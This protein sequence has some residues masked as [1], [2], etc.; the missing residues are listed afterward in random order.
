MIKAALY[1]ILLLGLAAWAFVSRDCR[2]EEE[3]ELS[4][5]LR[6]FQRMAVHIWQR[7][8]PVRQKIPGL[9][10]VRADLRLLHPSR[11]VIGRED[12]YYTGK[13]RNL[14]LFVCAADLLAAA[15]FLG[16]QTGRILEN[17]RRIERNSYGGSDRI[18]SLTAMD[19][20]RTDLGRFDLQVSARRYR[21][22]D[23]IRM[24][25]DL[26]EKL[27]DLILADNPDLLHVSTDLSL[28]S[29]AE[30]YPFILQWDTAS[31]SL[32]NT[33]G[34]VHPDNLENGTPAKVRLRASLKYDPW[35]FETEIPVTV[36]PRSLTEEEAVR[37]SI[38]ESLAAAET[39]GRET[40]ACLLPDRA[41]GISL[42]WREN[43]TDLSPAVLLGV[44]AAGAAGFF[45]TD[46]DLRK[47]VDSRKREMDLDY[48][49]I[50]SKFVLYLGAG[51]SVRSVFQ[52]LAADYRL[53]T[54]GRQQIYTGGDPAGLS[55]AGQRDSGDHG[56]RTFRAAVPF[57]AVYPFLLPADPEPEEGEQRPAG[58][59]A[60][61]ISGSLR[62]TQE[63]SPGAWGRGRHKAAFPH[64]HYAGGDHADHH[65]AGL[66]RIH[67]SGS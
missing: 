53:E 30:G 66:L 14:L 11:R 17:G 19:P 33:N 35:V 25:D 49:H 42:T 16:G 38:E 37:Q 61:G 56:L 1:L 52:K 39:S 22:E 58:R 44:L 62:R 15:V 67:V 4:P 64:D 65:C 26:T 8:K 2:S 31:Y 63:Y 29:A 60:G 54:G 7:L 34:E 50:L 40:E 36:V 48:P 41:G 55:R 12:A 13:I 24:A 27:P 18:L 9:E 3:A 23:V 28:V 10:E 51:M 21:Q 6:I 46:R 59:P 20:G 45:L 43:R 5:F 47:S 32:V 57:P